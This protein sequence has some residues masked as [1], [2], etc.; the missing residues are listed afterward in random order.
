M[1]LG[2]GIRRAVPFNRY[3]LSPIIDVLVPVPSKTNQVVFITK[4]IIMNIIEHSLSKNVDNCAGTALSIA[5]LN[6]PPICPPPPWYHMRGSRGQTTSRG[7]KL[8]LMVLLG[9]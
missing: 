8:V 3:S 2:T 9:T 6:L 1:L 7:S 4:L 5:R